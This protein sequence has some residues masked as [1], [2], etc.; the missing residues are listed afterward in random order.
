MKSKKILSLILLVFSV[1][2][3]LVSISGV[4]AIWVTQQRITD[5]VLE[6]TRAAQADLSK[7]EDDIDVLREELD[8]AKSQIDI[9]QSVLDTIGL[10]AVENAQVVSDVVSKVEGTIT[11]ILD[12][13]NERANTVRDTF[14]SLKE[15][16]ERVNELPLVNIEVPGLEIIDTIIENIDNLQTQVTDTKTKVESISQLTQDTV[17]TLTTGFENWEESI[18]VYQV[19]LDD[20]QNMISDY[21][22]RLLYLELNLAGWVD[23]ASI[24]LTVLLIWTAFSQVALFVTA[25][26]FYKEEDLLA[27][28]R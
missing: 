1:F 27:R 15:S 24:I 21:Q 17:E 18:A 2:F 4:I 16:I 13:V 7:V 9:F 14:V 22:D 6:Q 26:S 12:G 20:Y 11:P 8:S 5:R 25:W 19:T 10:E 3:F 28:W 23:I